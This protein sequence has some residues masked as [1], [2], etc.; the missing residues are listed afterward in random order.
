MAGEVPTS[1]G[2]DPHAVTVIETTGQATARTSHG[3][4][5]GPPTAR[6]Q[7]GALIGRG[8][9]G[10]VVAAT[11]QQI[12][13]EVAIKRIR[14]GA[15]TDDGERRF[16][17]EAQV[18]GRLEHPAIVPVHELSTDADGQPY[19]VMKKL[20]GE[21]LARVLASG[22][23]SRQRLLR[24]FADVCLAI[25]FAHTKGVVHRDLKPSNIML[26]DFGEVYVLD[27]GI[28]RVRG[29]AAEA[30][31]RPLVADDDPEGATVTGT[32]LGTPG[33]MAPEQIRGDADLDGRA[34]IYALGCVLFELLAGQPLHP[35]GASAL[36]STSRGLDARPSAR[37]PERA[38]AP[39]LDAIVVRACALAA[40]DRFA[41]AR[42]LADQVTAFLDG[43]RDVAARR[44]Q[45]AVHLDRARAALA[46]PAAME[47]EASRKLAIREAS[48]AFTLDPGADDAARL[49]TRLM[50]SPPSHT[51][52]EV[53]DELADLDTAAAR[54][55]ARLGTWA[56]I[57]YLGFLP[58]LIAL[59]VRAPS[60]V[61]GFAAT[62]LGCAAIAWHFSRQPTLRAPIIGALILGEVALIA[63][64]ARMFTPFLVAPGVAGVTLMAFARHPRFG[65]L[66]VIW[67]AMTAG[68]LV[69]YA[70]EALGVI[71][72]TMTFVDDT[73]G[74]HSPAFLI[75]PIPTQLG[76]A[77]CTAVM[78]GVSAFFARQSS[79]AE[80]DARRQVAIQKWQLRQ[81]M[82][83]G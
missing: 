43:D 38:I 27:W 29:D 58:V 13:R 68:V 17:R 12:G 72:R 65:R 40:A 35:A 37:A 30:T 11:D 67:A 61:V 55:Q 36:T 21:T 19:F 54:H 2:P 16:L 64:F 45:A 34:D 62:V 56:T 63:L 77:L 51:P 32:L 10:E 71:E 3:G 1:R 31:P 52:P 25:E 39:E 74:L 28:A 26:G 83:Q 49:V 66:E 75:R 73:L 20:T 82:P 4:A 60:Y 50:L 81:L 59:G 18:Q 79:N 5:A 33:Y 57:G 69:P 78:L 24:A 70:L 44:H 15:R 23:A 22:A 46:A 7:L 8:G 42:E 6:Y 14:A 80:R 53:E 47:D 48:A 41:T 76:L 9:M